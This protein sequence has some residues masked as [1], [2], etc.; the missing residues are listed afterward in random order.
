M[1]SHEAVYTPHPLA[2]LIRLEK[3]KGAYLYRSTVR[4]GLVR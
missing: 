3:K 2:M 4:A 1:V